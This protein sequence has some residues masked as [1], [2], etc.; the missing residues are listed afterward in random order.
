[1]RPSRRDRL[2]ENLIH[3]SLALEICLSLGGISFTGYP[4]VVSLSP[5][6]HFLVRLVARLVEACY[7]SIPVE[8]FRVIRDRSIL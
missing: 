3:S 2:G 4:M 7:F 8:I 5:P 6:M 1:V